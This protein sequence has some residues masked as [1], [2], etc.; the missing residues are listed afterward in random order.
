MRYFRNINILALASLFVSCSHLYNDSDFFDT[1]WRSSNGTSIQ[2]T[3]NGTCHVEGLRWDLLFRDYSTNDSSWLTRPNDFNG[4]WSIF[5]YPSGLQQL[6]IKVDS[7]KY[8]CSFDIQTDKAVLCYI[9]DPDLG[10]TYE[11]HRI[12]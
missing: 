8:V 4:K 3:K 6:I 1:Q 12:E 7:S 10:M 9:G 5:S 2:L 11:L